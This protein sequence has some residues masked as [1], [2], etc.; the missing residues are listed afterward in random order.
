MTSVTV[1]P[2]DRAE[3]DGW[4]R[5]LV[6]EFAAEQVAAGNWE[7]GTAEQQTRDQLTHLLPQG[8]E[9][10]HA[11]FY[12]GVDHD[13]EPVGRAWVALERRGGPAGVAFLYGFDVVAA[14]RGQGL[15]RALLSAVEDAVRT[16][17][18]TALELNVFGRNAAAV[19]LYESSGY[20]VMTQQ[21]RKEL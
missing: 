1:R 18:A 17:G 9:T 15:G 8:M 19:G 21:M 10:A 3:F 6:A 12:Q 4:Q 14:R 13:G 11:A 2:M 16:A 7:P 20:A 5:E